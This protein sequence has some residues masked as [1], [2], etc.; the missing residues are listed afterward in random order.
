MIK[1]GIPEAPSREGRAPNT[2]EGE[3][4]NN[5]DGCFS[6][7]SPGEGLKDGR[8]LVPRQDQ[9]YENDKMGGT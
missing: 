6:Q 3:P 7:C 2:L 1:K 5:C 8:I 9:Q 4:L